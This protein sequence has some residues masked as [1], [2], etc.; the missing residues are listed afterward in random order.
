MDNKIV[1][2][3]EAK[4][5]RDLDLFINI[6]NNDPEHIRRAKEKAQR[7]RED[8]RKAE[9]KKVQR[10][11]E[12]TRREFGVVLEKDEIEE[13]AKMATLVA[14]IAAVS[15]IIANVTM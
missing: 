2:I 12:K 8:V 13:N 4:M 15:Q 11:I 7:V 6:V 10:I 14:A 3:K 1:T 9:A 5:A